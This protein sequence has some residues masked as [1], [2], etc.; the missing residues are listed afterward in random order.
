MK[1][2]NSSM[3]GEKAQDRSRTSVST[4][5][6][7]NS[8]PGLGM[9]AKIGSAIEL[10]LSSNSRVDGGSARKMR[11]ETNE[12]GQLP[13]ATTKSVSSDRGTFQDIC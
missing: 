8:G 7:K 10:G 2:P 9:K 5:S 3:A 13:K 11:G 6:A 4:A 12:A 1:N